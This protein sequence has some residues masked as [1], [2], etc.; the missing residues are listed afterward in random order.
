MARGWTEKCPA[1]FQW[2]GEWDEDENWASPKKGWASEFGLERDCREVCT[3]Q[4]HLK[5]LRFGQLI[6]E[7]G[8][9]KAYELDRTLDR[10]YEEILAYHKRT[11]KRP[12]RVTPGFKA[13]DLW[14]RGQG[15]SISQRCDELELPALLNLNRNLDRCDEVIRAHYKKTGKRPTEKTSGFGSWSGWLRRQG[16]SLSQRCDELG[17]SALHE[18]GRTLDRCDEAIRAHYKKT[19]KRPT[20]RTPGFKA[21]DFWLRSHGNSSLSQRCNELGLP[22]LHNL[23]RT[24]G[25]C[26]QLIL[27]YYKKTG[28]RPTQRTSGFSAWQNW[29]RYNQGSSLS[30]RCDE[31]GLRNR[32]TSK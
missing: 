2:P 1:G 12:T 8:G 25:Q 27:A 32:S 23:D 6:E 17:L 10:C 4:Y 5:R 15:S 18:L 3:L 21:C 26:D 29:L 7:L 30:Q 16:S 22:V 24:M 20:D 31:L 14:L 19:G 28:K 9:P 13:W 11:G